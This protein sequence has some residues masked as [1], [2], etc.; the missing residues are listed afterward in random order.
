LV[1]SWCL[2]LGVGAYR[3]TKIDPMDPDSETKKQENLRAGL[4]GGA[5]GGAALGTGAAYAIPKY[6]EHKTNKLIEKQNP[7]FQK[8]VKTYKEKRENM[9]WLG[10]LTHPSEASFK[11]KLLLNNQAV[12]NRVNKLVTEKK[13]LG[14]HWPFGKTKWGITRSVKKEFKNIPET[15]NSLKPFSSGAREKFLNIKKLY[16]G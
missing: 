7:G 16:K 10:K 15:M 8:Q 6:Y 14:L 4:V 9:N 12:G 5:I 3:N 1:V 2:G 11:K 13:N